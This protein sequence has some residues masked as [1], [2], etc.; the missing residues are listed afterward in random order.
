ML[1]VFLPLPLSVVKCEGGY[2]TVE[3]RDHGPEAAAEE[4]GAEEYKPFIPDDLEKTVFGKDD[5]ITVSN[6]ASYPFS[7]IAYMEVTGKCGCDW[8]A[9]GYM[10]G[11]DKMLTAAHC[12][13]CTEHWEQAEKIIFYFGYKNRRNYME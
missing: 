10:V 4:V 8:T 7:A 1:L 3:I 12:L 6:P 9:S 11:T 2:G 5:S 13:F